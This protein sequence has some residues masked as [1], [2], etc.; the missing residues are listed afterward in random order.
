MH[1]HAQSQVE[2]DR[3]VVR[4]VSG[5]DQH[6]AITTSIN[7][8]TLPPSMSGAIGMW[9]V[10]TR[11][12]VKTRSFVGRD[13]SLT[14]KTR[15]LMDRG[16]EARTYRKPRMDSAWK[17]ARTHRKQRVDCGS[18][19]GSAQVLQIAYGSWIWTW[20]RASAVN[21]ARIVPGSAQVL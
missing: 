16:V 3:T 13:V 7:T 11:T 8:S 15:S 18:G 21:S 20:K 14:M 9:I 4:V 10:K 12:Y 2:L 6:V 19:R 17:H 1:I 5:S